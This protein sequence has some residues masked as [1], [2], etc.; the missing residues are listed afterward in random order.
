MKEILEKQAQSLN[1]VEKLLGMDR[2]IQLSQAALQLKTDKDINKDEQLNLDKLDSISKT[3]KEMNSTLSKSEK[4]LAK[5]LSQSLSEKASKLKKVTT[6]GDIAKEK[7]A[8]VKDFFTLRGFLDKSG[9]AKRGGGGTLSR[10]ADARETQKEFVQQ[11]LAVTKNTFVK[12]SKEEKVRKAAATKQFK[13]SQKLLKANEENESKIQRFK[14]AGWSDDQISKTGLLERRDAITNSLQ[15]VDKRVGSIAKEFTA[16]SSKEETVS[17]SKSAAAT[18]TPS[19]ESDVEAQRLRE[20]Q[21]GLLEKIEQNTAGLK[22]TS[23]KEKEGNSSGGGGLLSGFTGALGPF[24]GALGRLGNGIGK[25]LQGMLIGLARGFAA[26]VNPVTLVGMGA[27]TIAA[28]GIG[29]ALQMAAPAIQAFAPIV[30]SVADVI[31]NVFVEGIKA[32]PDIIS[33][34]GNVI[35]G[36]ITSIADGIKGVVDMVVTSIERLAKIDGSNLLSVAAGLVAIG[37]GMAAFAAGNVAAGLTNFVGGLFNA[38]TGQKSPLEQLEAIAKLGPGLQQAGDG[39]QKVSAGLGSFNKPSPTTG[40]TVT[41]MTNKMNDAK[42]AASQQQ[43]SN[44]IVS[45]PTTVTNSNK[46]NIAMPQPI[47]NSDSGFASYL[48]NKMS[49]V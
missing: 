45:A 44:V 7:V 14:D 40:T 13:Q 47:R 16:S 4:L 33:S 42:D 9:I 39:L 6:V 3:L 26:L 10:L 49:F 21:V 2:L 27:F 23:A 15:K 41:G 11:Q 30:E 48:K 43:K 1:R 35:T 32:I 24:G 5:Q 31:K 29:K 18:S 12:G 22:P 46:Q 36:I 37:A 17:R 25:G 38:V 19:V 34:I 8:S 28:M 20:K